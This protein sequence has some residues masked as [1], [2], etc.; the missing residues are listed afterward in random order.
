MK[1]MVAVFVLLAV[2]ACAPGQGAPSVTAPSVE[3]TGGSVSVAGLVAVSGGSCDLADALPGYPVC[4]SIYTCEA[5]EPRNPVPGT[6]CQKC[7]A[8]YF[9]LEGTE[10]PGQARR[11]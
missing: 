1:Q 5:T 4:S 10:C 11:K 7:T 9:S 3:S 2:V 8:G 6:C